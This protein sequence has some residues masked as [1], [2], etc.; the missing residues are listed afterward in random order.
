VAPNLQHLY[1]FLVDNRHVQP[2]RDFNEE[3]LSIHSRDVYR[4]MREGDPT[5]IHEVPPGVALL[6][7]QDH[8]M[9]YDPVVFE[10]R[11]G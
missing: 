5:W 10:T 4:R 7:C 8:L 11:S 2:L 6:I 3:Y 1:K 9:G